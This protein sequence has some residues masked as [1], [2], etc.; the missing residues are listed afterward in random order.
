MARIKIRIA[1]DGLLAEA[2]VVAGSKALAIDV[3]QALAAAWVVFG[4]DAAAVEVLGQQVADPAYHGEVVLARGEAA[5]PTI[6]GL[7]KLELVG[8]SGVGVSGAGANEKDGTID[9]RERNPLQAAMVDEV[10]GSLV[11]PLPGVPGRDVRGQTLK[12]AAV[13]PF[14]PRLGLGVRAGANGTIVANRA[15]VVLVKRNKFVDVVD[16]WKHEGDVDLRSGNLHTKGSLE[17]TGDLQEGGTATSLGDAVIGGSVLDGCLRAA[18]SVAISGGVM[19]DKCVVTVGGDV[20][21]HHATSAIITAEGNM[22]VAAQL[23]HCWVQANSIE[24][25]HG[26]GQAFGGELRASSS[27]KMLVAGTENGATTLVVIGTMDAS[28]DVVV[29]RDAVKADKSVRVGEAAKASAPGRASGRNWRG[30]TILI[31]EVCWPGVRIQ[32]GHE[33]VDIHEPLKHVG[34]RWDGELEEITRFELA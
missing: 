4:I 30:C 18:G 6:H 10:V 27:I 15:G 22:R 26:R 7:I 13:K 24:L 28:E 2:V 17:I 25:L 32:F 14:A 34:F 12:V 3:K 5:Q 19:G 29:R 16:L 9:F 23:S 31:Q 21:F 8:C 11:M 33:F 20:Q 1:S